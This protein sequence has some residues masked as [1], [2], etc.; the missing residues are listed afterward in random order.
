MDVNYFLKYLNYRLNASTDHDVHSPFVFSFYQ[1]LIGKPYSCGDFDTLNR[2]RKQMLSDKTRITFTD[3]GAGS[4]ALKDRER[5][6]KD[7]AKHGIARRKQ[8][9]FLYR[10]VRR[11]QPAT[12]IEL[13]TSLGLSSLYLAKASANSRLYTIEGCPQLAAYAH[14]QFNAQHA[15]N[16]VPITGNFDEALPALLET[17]DRVDLAYVDGN[18]AYEPTLRYFHQLLER[19][20]PGTILVFDDL[21]WSNGMAQAWKTIH[22]HPDV[23][24]SIDL[25]Q[26]GIVFFRT[27]QKNKEHFILRF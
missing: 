3:L 1:E 7:I 20:H 25:F 8:A 24:L 2:L 13:G 6:V 22:N 26:F 11:F 9:E 21:Y 17:L 27:E 18:H 19:R 16:I 15:G 10:L 5:V 23:R 4:K 12:I 14:D